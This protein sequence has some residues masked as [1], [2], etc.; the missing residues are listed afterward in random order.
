LRSLRA[1]VEGLKQAKPAF[2]KKY[3]SQQSC[4]TIIGC[5]RQVVGKFLSREPIQTEYFQNICAEI[6]LKWEE[7]AESEADIQPP[8]QDCE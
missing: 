8:I 5:T 3:T 2:G 4:A 1:S 7:I 6:G